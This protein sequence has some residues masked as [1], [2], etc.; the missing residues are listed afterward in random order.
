MNIN[1]ESRKEQWNYIFK[2]FP[3]VELPFGILSVIVSPHWIIS[4][5]MLPL[6]PLMASTILHYAEKKNFQPGYLICS[7]N[8]SIFLLFVYICG[9]EAPS[10]PMIVT[11][12]VGT[13]FMFNNPRVG[14]AL[15]L[16]FA[17][18]V[19][20]LF[21]F[22]GAGVIYSIT[23][24]LTLVSFVLIFARTYDYMRLQQKR[25]EQKQQ[26]ILDSIH[27][28]QR[29]QKS[30]ITNEKYIEKSLLRLKKEA[31]RVRT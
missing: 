9:P 29:I 16:I 28:A 8:G 2:I 21:Y 30:L 3:I 6:F 13:S 27:Y 1:L 26:E 7:I 25:I 11:V 31:E 24:M 22:M 15:M 20:S 17:C 12:S 18:M 10:W 5:C 4:L 19:A 14:Q 23:I